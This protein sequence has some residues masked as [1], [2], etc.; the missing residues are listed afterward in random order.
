MCHPNGT[1][2]RRER[3]LFL[4]RG[5]PLGDRALSELM[6]LAKADSL[7]HVFNPEHVSSSLSDS[8]RGD[9][10]EGVE[11]AVLPSYCFAV[12]GQLPFGR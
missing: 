6:I 9:R 5:R 11:A 7:S 8:E 1:P 12:P 4:L 10:C 3:A 2:K